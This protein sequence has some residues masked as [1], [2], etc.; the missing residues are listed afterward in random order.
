MITMFQDRLYNTK[1]S[2]Y[3]KNYKLRQTNFNEILGNF[4]MKARTKPF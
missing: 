4:V 1:H 2:V 3:F